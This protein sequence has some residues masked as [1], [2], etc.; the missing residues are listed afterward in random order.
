V[1]DKCTR[2]RDV[3]GDS[4]RITNETSHDVHGIRLSAK[5][6]VRA[7]FGGGDEEK[8][9]CQVALLESSRL[10]PVKK[11]AEYAQRFSLTPELLP[12]E[13]RRRPH[14]HIYEYICIH[15]YS[16]THTHTFTLTLTLTHALAR[17]YI[18]TH[19]HARFLSLSLSLSRLFFAHACVRGSDERRWARATTL[20]NGAR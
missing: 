16:L 20:R 13:V 8:Y 18:H 7:R 3:D 9:K 17:L 2:V 5:Q 6:V 19:V 10:C 4:V 11:G 15:I 14:T 12:T 1:T